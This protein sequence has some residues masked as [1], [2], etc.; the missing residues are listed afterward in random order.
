LLPT[1]RGPD[2]PV[3]L[4]AR[5]L[6]ARVPDPARAAAVLPDERGGVVW[7]PTTAAGPIDRDVLEAWVLRP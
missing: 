7:V 6:A 2:V 3:D 4:F 5:A 1:S